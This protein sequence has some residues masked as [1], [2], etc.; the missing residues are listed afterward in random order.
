METEPKEPGRELAAAADG[1]EAG[2]ALL[3]NATARANLMAEMVPALVRCCHERDI[4]DMGGKPFIG[5]SGCE[6]IARVAGIS[7]SKPDVSAGFE[8]DENGKKIYTVT[9]RGE[10]S[11]MAQSVFEVGGCDEND[12]FIA[13]KKLALIARKLDVEKKAYCN[14]RGR[15]VRTLLGLNGLSWKDLEKHGITR[16]GR[17]RVDY[18]EGKHT[19]DRKESAEES[20]K[21]DEV[22]TKIRDQLL[23]DLGSP[24][25]AGKALAELT[26]FVGKD[27]NKRAGVGSVNDARFSDKWAF[28]TW[29]DIRKDGG[30]DRERYAEVILAIQAAASKAPEGKGSP[31]ND[32]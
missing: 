21:V 28:K 30:K 14:W 10:C 12:K 22:K 16:E 11:L 19:A 4:T 18:K 23:H 15:C 8:A 7:F 25:L 2:L 31:E 20:E 27:G 26:S 1:E 13:S 6:K 3:E 17:T 24:D 32:L 29:S 5:D 9:M